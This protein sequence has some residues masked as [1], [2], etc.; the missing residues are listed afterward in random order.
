MRGLFGARSCESA[1]DVA[2]GP[3]PAF[4]FP[5]SAPADS[6]AAAGMNPKLAS[7]ADGCGLLLGSKLAALADVAAAAAVRLRK[8]RVCACDGEGDQRDGETD[9]V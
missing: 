2:S 8:P 3:A 6:A 5:P 4:F 7:I 1:S 9:G